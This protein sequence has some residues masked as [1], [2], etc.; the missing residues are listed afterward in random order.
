ME[1]NIVK[2]TNQQKTAEV[3][4]GTTI[5][6]AARM[7]GLK[8]D[9]VCGGTGKCGKCAVVVITDS[10]QKK[11]L[12]CQA[13]ITESMEIILPDELIAAEIVILTGTDLEE[14][15]KKPAV[16][17]V[18]IP[19]RAVPEPEC[20]G[21]WQRLT[22]YLGE[23]AP[24]EVELSL[25]RR[26]PS[27][28]RNRKL[29]GITLVQSTEKLL[30]IEEEDTTDSLYGMAI[31]IGTTSV[32]GYLYDLNSGEKVAISSALNG[33]VA[34]G[35][36]VMSRIM[37]ASTQ[38]GLERLQ[39][40]IVNTINDVI[41]NAAIKA[42]IKSMDI[43][44]LVL[45]G[46]TTMQHLFFALTPE[47]LGRSPFT[48]V[49]Q[50]EITIKSSEAGININPE[51]LVTF[52]PLIGGFVGADTTGVVLATGM[53][54]HDKYRLMI[55]IGTNG[56]IV[57]G[58]KDK[59]L[60][61]S[62]AA[63]PA[64]EGAGIGFGMRGTDGAIERVEINDA[65]V[66]LKVIGNTKVKGICGS[67]LVDLAAELLR[68]NI[69]DEKGKLLSAEEFLQFGSEALASRLK[70]VDGKRVFVIASGQETD[71]GNDV[72]LSQGDIRS[73]Q[74]AKG[75]IFTG[76]MILLEEYG[77]KGEDLEEIM[78]AGAFGNYIDVKNAQAIGL[79]PDFIGVPVRPVGNGAGG[80]AQLALLSEDIRKIAR[81][82]IGSIDHVELAT[83]REF[84]DRFIMSLGFDITHN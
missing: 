16:Q 41:E 38:D 23:S 18:F 64:L 25:L 24:K 70:E 76:C 60:A 77:I 7:A 79:L 73:L 52:L 17:K 69:I 43:Y 47:Y 62:T 45:V 61:C 6:E 37:A 22:Q 15:I 20:S 65:G 2:F 9:L 51:G 3:N 82:M 56:E 1:K 4:S 34:E 72:Y 57:L 32:A 35:A 53:Y 80:G 55:D 31:D 67:G 30:S 11:V 8:L 44:Q 68:V 81:D 49:N 19:K 75:A 12:A 83:H 39:Q 63:G 58:N 48:A 66:K 46:N 5:A 26:L 59:M 71:S 84:Q 78:L 36:D 54:Q 21:D 10:G 74:L 28:M 42:D 50:G 29:T 14:V 40:L 33:Q 13:K 27:L